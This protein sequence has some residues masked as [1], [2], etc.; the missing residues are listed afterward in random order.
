M[1]TQGQQ[2]E[3][4]EYPNSG[5]LFRADPNRTSDRPQDPNRKPAD[6]SGSGEIT[7]TK[8][9]PAGTVIE[10]FIDGYVRKFTDKR[11]R[12]E[13]ALLSLRFKPK[14]MKKSQAQ[15]VSGFG[16]Q[17]APAPQPQPQPQP[18]HEQAPDDGGFD[19]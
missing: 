9:I 15:A 1:S 10:F 6:Y 16:R 2:K 17:A 13:K 3:K 8:D 14:G 19:F 11:T 4:K 7:V 18:S 12:E 5:A